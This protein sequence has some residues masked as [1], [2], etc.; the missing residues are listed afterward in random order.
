MCTGP[1]P[2]GGPPG[3]HR[4]AAAA[5]CSGREDHRATPRRKACIPWADAG[6][7]HMQGRCVTAPPCHADRA[8]AMP[9]A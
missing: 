4:A 7:A 8:H 9:A 1:R 3:R 2:E 5:P 6:A